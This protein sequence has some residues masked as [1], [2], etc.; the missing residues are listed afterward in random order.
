MLLVSIA[1]GRRTGNREMK[2]YRPLDNP[3][4]V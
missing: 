2:V 4:Y 1:E 3:S